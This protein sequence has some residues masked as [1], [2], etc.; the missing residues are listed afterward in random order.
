MKKDLWLTCRHVMMM[1]VFTRH[2]IVFTNKLIIVQHIQL[3]TGTQLFPTY[4]ARKAI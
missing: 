1:C 4:T 2:V 3:F